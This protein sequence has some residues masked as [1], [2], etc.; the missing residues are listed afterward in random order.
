MLGYVVAEG[1]GAADRLIRD[2][3]D[4]LRQEGVPLAGAVQVNIENDPALKCHMDLHILN[5]HQVVR[6]S[7]NLGAL[8]QG[9]RLDPDGLERA[10]GLSEAGLASGAKL[11]IVNKFGKQEADGRGFRPVIGQ[12]LSSDIPVLTAVGPG[13]LPAF[14]DYADGLAE[15]LPNNTDEVVQWCKD[16]IAAQA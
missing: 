11:M 2:V 15:Q 5:G 4:R 8:S 10:V 3:A 6:I 12:A 14:L 7:Q 1:Q 16:Q 9:C 13:N